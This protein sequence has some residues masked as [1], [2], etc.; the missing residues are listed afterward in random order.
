MFT[1]GHAIPEL[2][3]AVFER[4][5]S[6][7]DFYNCALVNRQFNTFAISFLYRDL[8]FVLV[9][10][11][12]H[13]QQKL[14]N[15]LLQRP[16]L[17]TKIR[18]IVIILRSFHSPFLLQDD[19]LLNCALFGENMSRILQN[20]NQLVCL[21]FIN[22]TRI[23]ESTQLCMAQIAQNAMTTILCSI[24]T[25]QNSGVEISLHLHQCVDDGLGGGDIEGRQLAQLFGTQVS[26]LSLSDVSARHLH[27]LGNFSQ[28]RSLVFLHPVSITDG[29]TIDWET[30]FRDV[31]LTT[32]HI[33]CTAFVSLPRTL[34]HLCIGNRDL[35][36]TPQP[37]FRQTCWAAICR[38]EHLSSLNISYS[39]DS[40]DPWDGPPIHFNSSNLTSLNVRA[41]CELG[42][43]GTNIN[44]LAELIF[45]PIFEHH[46]LDMI[47]LHFFDED[48]PEEF[49]AS[50]FSAGA[51]ASS[52]QINNDNGART[53]HFDSLVNAAINTPHLR[54]LRF[55]WPS[56]I[57]IE[58]YDT[59]SRFDHTLE[60]L[61]FHQCQQLARACP[62]LDIVQFPIG[63]EHPDDDLWL[64]S[65]DT[66]SLERFNALGYKCREAR[67]AEYF[68]ATKMRRLID[69]ASPCLN[70]CT[71]LYLDP[72]P[73]IDAEHDMTLF[74]S[75]NQV[76]KHGDHSYLPAL[77]FDH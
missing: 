67:K 58:D 29:P 16:Q 13:R 7:H 65:R 60:A 77:L 35:R 30:I 36:Q 28:L 25:L 45:G 47:A 66:T 44:W 20:A 73:Y 72:D 46:H 63:N 54:A 71:I 51:M 38:L 23:S 15:R 19:H 69:Y 55:P 10:G 1:S 27:H 39:S 33:Q 32:L 40:F 75:L 49:L 2:L 56:S 21:E 9:W 22:G 12:S 6:R 57:R 3:G 31:P 48:V 53:Y 64:R 70:V 34:Q 24:A 61:N 68:Q 26:A 52:I 14:I 41:A 5:G 76:R 8:T 74:L 62:Q 37:P 42:D 17:T 59:E 4:L 50:V 11:Q 18:K 43:V